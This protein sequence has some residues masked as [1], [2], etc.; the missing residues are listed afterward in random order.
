MH[1][2]LN[3]QDILPAEQFISQKLHRVR[4]A[5]CV[6]SN[7]VISERDAPVYAL[8]LAEEEHE[9]FD[10]TDSKAGLFERYGGAGIKHNGG[11]VRCAIVDGT[12]LKG[13]GRSPL[14]GEGT[15]YFHS[16]GGMSLREAVKDTIWGE[17]MSCA[18]PYGAARIQQIYLLPSKVPLPYK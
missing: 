7:H 18:L 5:S 14:A 12:S 13:V 6:Y 16:F 15:D 4:R 9:N 2:R 17:I 3:L 8:P 1:K 10:P 11:G